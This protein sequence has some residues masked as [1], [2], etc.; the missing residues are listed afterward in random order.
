MTYKL[1][2]ED[3]D[4]SKDLV[5]SCVYNIVDGDELQIEQVNITTDEPKSLLTMLTKPINDNESTIS[6]IINNESQTSKVIIN[7]SNDDLNKCYDTSANNKMKNVAADIKRNQI[8]TSLNDENIKSKK[9][10]TDNNAD[11]DKPLLIVKNGKVV[12]ICNICDYEADS[13]AFLLSHR[14]RTHFDTGSFKC[15]ECLTYHKTAGLLKR[16]MSLYHDVTHVCKYCDKRFASKLS[17]DR[18]VNCTHNITPLEFQ[19]VKCNA[20]FDTI[21]KM[22]NHLVVHYIN[23][24]STFSCNH[25]DRKFSTY[26]AKNKHI[27]LEHMVEI[28]CDICHVVLPNKEA[29]DK[30]TISVHPPKKKGNQMYACTTCG[31]YFSSIKDILIHRETHTS[32]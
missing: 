4:T 23:H 1:D 3:Q 20:Y 15:T 26:A 25:C 5:D 31:Q 13:M 18:H 28:E 19:C 16:H 17:L 9:K 21:D 32:K 8:K 24:S 12:Y 11:N 2:L 10:K 27:D 30:H 22:E 14:T 29:M 6:V 7:E